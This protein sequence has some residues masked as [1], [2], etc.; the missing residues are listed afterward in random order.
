MQFACMIWLVTILCKILN[1]K[2]VTKGF[3]WKDP[4]SWKREILLLQQYTKIIK[5]PPTLQTYFSLKF[6]KI[7][8]SPVN[9]ICDHQISN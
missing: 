6:I 4:P 2:V 5:I 7:N 9:S 1:L 3:S 8:T